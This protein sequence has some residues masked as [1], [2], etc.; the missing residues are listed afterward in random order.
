MGHYGDSVKSIAKANSE[1]GILARP[2][3]RIAIDLKGFQHKG[4]RNN[5]DPFAEIVIEFVSEANFVNKLWVF[6]KPK[7]KRQILFHPDD[8]IPVT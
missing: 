4:Q 5:V 3:F 2:T 8:E 1:Q 6:V 7:I